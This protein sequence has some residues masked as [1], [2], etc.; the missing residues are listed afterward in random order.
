MHALLRDLCERH[1]PAVLLVTHD[2]D[3]AVVLADRVLVLDGGRITTDVPVDLGR[4]RDRGHPEFL[5]L[6]ARLLTDLGVTTP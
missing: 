3:E 5:A 2:V 1:S 6:R 4:P